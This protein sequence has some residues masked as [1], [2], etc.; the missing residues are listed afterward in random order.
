MKSPSWE[1]ITGLRDLDLELCVWKGQQDQQ[2]WTWSAFNGFTY[3]LP[4]PSAKAYL[5]S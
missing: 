1:P 2:T 3:P 4:I 5:S